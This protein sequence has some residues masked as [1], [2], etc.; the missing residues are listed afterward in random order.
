MI[1]GLNRLVCAL[2]ER[3]LN[4]SSLIRTAQILEVC[5]EKRDIQIVAKLRLV[6]SF[7]FL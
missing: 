5:F 3:R 7:L 4:L 1:D 6:S 2:L